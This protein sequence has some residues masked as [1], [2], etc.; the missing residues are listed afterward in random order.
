M[1]I[2]DTTEPLDLP[3]VEWCMA[4]DVFIKQ[5][6][7]ATANIIVKQ[8][9][10]TFDHTSLV[11]VGSVR[12]WK[13]GEYWQDVKAPMPIFIEKGTAHTFMSLE[14]NSIVYCIHNAKD[15]HVQIEEHL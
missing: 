14:D 13:N 10:H 2:P 9:T 8:H 4:D 11:A 7:M 3:E 1:E 15:G 5:M 6:S 12:V